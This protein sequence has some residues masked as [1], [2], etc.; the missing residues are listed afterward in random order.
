MSLMQ[1]K[2]DIESRVSKFDLDNDTIKGVIAD[3]GTSIFLVSN[4][5]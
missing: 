2:V 4:Q 1:L 3:T 5:Y